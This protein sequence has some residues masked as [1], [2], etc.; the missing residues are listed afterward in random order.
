M[1]HFIFPLQFKETDLIYEGIATAR[2]PS[3]PRSFA[4]K[5][6]DLIYEGIATHVAWV[7]SQYPLTKRN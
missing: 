5:E 1:V 6:T 4:R 2:V 3:H 7:S